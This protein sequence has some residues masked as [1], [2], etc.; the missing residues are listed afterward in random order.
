MSE[1]NYAMD[2]TYTIDTVED[3]ERGCGWR[4]KG[5]LYL[6]SAGLMSPCGRLPIL[7]PEKCPTCSGG[8][9]FVR[10]GWTWISPLKLWGRAEC[11]RRGRAEFHRRN[12]KPVSDCVACVAGLAIPERA[13]LLWIG[14]KHYTPEAWTA[15]AVSQ[16]V[17]RRI[18]SI[19]KEFVI[20]ETPVFVAHLKCVDLHLCD[21]GHSESAHRKSRCY[22][23]VRDEDGEQLDIQCD[24][25]KFK[26]RFQ[27]GVFHVFLPDRIEYVV[28]D[29]DD[30]AKLE[31]L[32]ERGVKL[33]RIA[34]VS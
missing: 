5:G 4:Q 8:L 27:A 12:V 26:G 15:E 30:P 33:V 1:T 21:C 24:C 28:D 25:A 17:S 16:G 19:P 20:G 10:T 31:R 14:G 29:D 3:Q 32:V 9:K 6:M 22:A 2:P 23:A 18:T 7:I 11:H 13:G 34:R